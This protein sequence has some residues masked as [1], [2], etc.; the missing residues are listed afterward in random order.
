MGKSGKEKGETCCSAKK[1]VS[2]HSSSTPNSNSGTGCVGTPVGGSSTPNTPGYLAITGIRSFRR[3]TS[4]GDL[5]SSCSAADLSDLADGT[6]T[7]PTSNIY[8]ESDTVGMSYEDNQRDSE[9]GNVRMVVQLPTSNAGQETKENGLEEHIHPTPTIADPPI[10]GHT[11]AVIVECEDEDYCGGW[12]CGIDFRRFQELYANTGSCNAGAVSCAEAG[13]SFGGVMG[14]T[15]DNFLRL[16]PNQRNRFRLQE[17]SMSILQP[18]NEVRRSVAEGDDDVITD[19]NEH[20]M[21]DAHR[22]LMQ[23]QRTKSQHIVVSV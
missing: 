13:Q 22:V 1:N 15:A 23:Q 7:D 20:M 4:R 9:S 8:G 19:Q 11:L 6:S 5:Q 2:K 3:S 18:T 12:T 14:A 21:I 10:N 17:L 16:F